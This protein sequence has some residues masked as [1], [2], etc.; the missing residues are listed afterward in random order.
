MDIAN[1]LNAMQIL[2][3]NIIM[4]GP[5][6]QSLGVEPVDHDVLKQK[7]RNVKQPMITK[8]VVVNVLLSASIIVLGTLWVFQREMADGTLGKTKRD[9][10]MT[11]TCFV[12]FD[13]FNALSCRSQTKS[14]FTI[15]LTTNRMF[16]LAVA[17]SIIGQMLVV[18]FPPLQMVFQTEALTPYDIFFLVSLTSSV[19]VVSEIK[20]WFER[21]ME[22]KMYSTR[23]ELDFV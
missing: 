15:G 6:A 19:L 20:K 4:D 18:Y 11:F 9:T 14:V 3:I 17:F 2:W 13:M 23:S 22:R 5:P 21:T 10:T 8:S 12:F 1:P 7:P 16:L